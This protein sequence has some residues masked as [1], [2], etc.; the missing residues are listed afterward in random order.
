MKYQLKTDHRLKCKIPNY[1][2][3]GP[4]VRQRLLTYGT[5]STIHKREKKINKLDFINIE[6]FGSVK[7]TV[8]RMKIQ[9]IDCN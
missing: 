8:T 9:A 7:D 2:S 3:V 5:R 4:W 1:N 6:N